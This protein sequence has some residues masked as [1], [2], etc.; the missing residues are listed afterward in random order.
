MTFLVSI[1]SAHS[2]PSA[3]EENLI[4]RS[5]V[6]GPSCAGSLGTQ[7]QPLKPTTM[8]LMFDAGIG[9]DARDEDKASRLCTRYLSNAYRIYIVI[10]HGAAD[11]GLPDR[12]VPPSGRK[13]T[14]RVFR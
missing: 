9:A 10:D 1:E 8:L 14:Q 7:Q 5:T 4:G 2:G 11:D 13:V 12:K 6:V 3:Y